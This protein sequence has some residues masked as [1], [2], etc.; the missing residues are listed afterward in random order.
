MILAVGN[1][2]VIR[3]HKSVSNI[4]V[5]GVDRVADHPDLVTAEVRRIAGKIHDLVFYIREVE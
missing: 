1:P 2:E 5:E 4:A 3:T